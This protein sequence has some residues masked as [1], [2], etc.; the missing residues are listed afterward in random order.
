MN[1]RIGEL[2]ITAWEKVNELDPDERER[3]THFAKIFAE[4]IVME[5]ITSLQDNYGDDCLPQEEIAG[6]LIE[7]FGVE[8]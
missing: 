2:R 5:C 4:L 1:E 3:D 7:H 6:F 8:Q